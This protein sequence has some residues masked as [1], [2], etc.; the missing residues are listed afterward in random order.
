[1]SEWGWSDKDKREEMTDDKAWYLIAKDIDNGNQPVAMVHFR[2]DLDNDDEVLYWWVE[3]HVSTVFGVVH[4]AVQAFCCFR[5][6]WRPCSILSEKLAALFGFLSAVLFI[7]V[8][9]IS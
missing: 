3:G 8:S 7:E 2:Y 5:F 1:M 4:S 9:G 6:I